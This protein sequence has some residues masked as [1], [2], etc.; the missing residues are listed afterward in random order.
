MELNQAFH[1]N[2]KKW[3]KVPTPQPA[4]SA[5]GD[6]NELVDPYCVSASKCFAAGLTASKTGKPKNEVLTW[7]GKQ[8]TPASV[9]QPAGTTPQDLGMPGLYGVRCVSATDCWAVGASHIGTNP[10]LNE[11]LHLSGKTWSRG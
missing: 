9:P 3:L 7:D 8:W 2:G 4:G 5:A 11:V 6:Q 10:I 1:W